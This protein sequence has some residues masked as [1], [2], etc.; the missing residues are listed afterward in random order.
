MMLA[1]YG[2]SIVVNR[3]KMKVGHIRQECTY[4][5]H[6]PGGKEIRYPA[7]NLPHGARKNP[8]TCIG[9]FLKQNYAIASGMTTQPDILF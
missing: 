4:L 8:Q 9:I 1:A 2:K 7:G 5:R 6:H 3:K